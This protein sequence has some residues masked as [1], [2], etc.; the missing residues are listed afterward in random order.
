MVEDSKKALGKSIAD[1]LEDEKDDDANKS[2]AD[3]SK[4]GETDG[5]NKPADKGKP[6]AAGKTDEEK[7][8][9]AALTLTKEELQEAIDGAVSKAVAQA[10]SSHDKDKERIRKEARDREEKLQRETEDARLNALSPEDRVKFQPQLDH[11]RR[12]RELKRREEESAG[13]YATAKAEQFIT[14]YGRFGVTQADLDKCENTA[15]MESVCVKKERDYWE[16]VA[17]GKIR[18]SD[19]APASSKNDKREKP[20]GATKK[21]DIGSQG[22]ASPSGESKVTSLDSFANDLAESGLVSS[23]GITRVEQK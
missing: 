5:G 15:E 8:A 12:E 17:T 21:P 7:K 9:D 16:G 4:P 6:D 18:P 3:T 1:D 13:I 10:N 11:E 20:A 22:P 14:Q 19:E 23:G 2:S